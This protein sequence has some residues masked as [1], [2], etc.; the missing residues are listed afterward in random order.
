[1]DDGNT[2]KPEQ[3][4]ASSAPT[5]AGSPASKDALVVVYRWS[6][7][8]I[9]AVV[10][11]V[12]VYGS[13]GCW[14]DVLVDFG[15]ELYIPWQLSEGRVLHADIA[16]LNG[17]LSAY[18]NALWFHLFGVSLSTLVLGNLVLLAVHVALFFYL[19]VRV[20]GRLAATCACLVWLTVFAFGQLISV[21][22]YNY[23]C[24]YAHEMTHG[25]LLCTAAIAC[26]YSY[27]R[28]GHVRWLSGAGFAIGLAF[29]TKPEVFLAGAA[30]LVVGSSLICHVQ[31]NH[32][33]RSILSFVVIIAS[34]IAP[35]AVAFLLLSLAMPPSQALSATAGSWA[36][37]FQVNVSSL[38]FY[39]RGMGL[40]DP[41]AQAALMVRWIGAYACLFVPIGWIALIVRKPGMHHVVIALVVSSAVAF[42][43][44]WNIHD[45]EWRR[46]AM[47]WPVFVA[48]IGL[49]SAV[50]AARRPENGEVCSRLVL[51]CTLSTFALV[52]LGKMAL[53]ARL[54]Q[55]GFALALPATMLIVVAMIEWIPAFVRGRKGSAWVFLGAS[56]AA[57]AVG[58]FVHV[59]RSYDVYRDKTFRVSS[60]TDEFR[61]DVRGDAVST[62][63][64]E[65]E[66]HV[67][68]DATLAVFPEGVMLN[69]LA[70]R[71]NPTPYINFM[72]LELAIYGES[73][74]LAA[75][76]AQPPEYVVL[77]H[78]D[79]SEYGPRFFGQDYAQRLF[80]WIRE[81]YRPISLV[82]APPLQSDDFGILLLNR[83][84]H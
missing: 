25:L 50:R 82:G 76:E 5:T 19:L 78:K 71:A 74:I 43:L 3:A 35:V 21:G 30:A 67:P 14:P 73:R 22:N 54:H 49:I 53:N 77:V 42:G 48:A 68:V 34:A 6:G 72:P 62:M 37:M 26:L 47:P 23:V 41:V 1:M 65:I 38:D 79:T 75:L 64:D 63:L 70:R 28:S 32:R 51:V 29:L 59:Q 69:Y 9:I 36:V 18:V 12:L 15:R 24:P 44:T 8:T 45:I 16:H 57:L 56:L 7:P 4:K 27:H 55:Y 83:S 10:G 13:W 84:P 31:D 58:A 66:L 40:L 33:S 80:E 46:L 39:R 17:P 81:H 60:G 20:A 11:I 61:A 2:E 52:L